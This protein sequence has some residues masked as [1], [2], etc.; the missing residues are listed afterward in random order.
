ME[1][2]RGT[3]SWHVFSKSRGIIPNQLQTISH[4]FHRT[5]LGST[6]EVMSSSMFMQTNFIDIL[7]L[8]LKNFN[9]EIISPM[10]VLFGVSI[11]AW[12]FLYTS[13]EFSTKFLGNFM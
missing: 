10:Q 9:N 4:E 13:Y 6:V 3:Y 8:I 5:L 1:C 12:T 2:F 7:S 11:Q